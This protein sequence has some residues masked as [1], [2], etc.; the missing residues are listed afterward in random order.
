MPDAAR[1]R[2]AVVVTD[3][4][5]PGDPDRDTPALLAALRG[6]GAH[7]QAAVWHDG[8]VEWAGFDLAVLRTPW[9]WATRRAEF[10]GWLDRV[11][12]LTRVLNPPPLVRWN[13]DKRYLAELAQA[14]IAVV[15]TTYHRD[16]DHLPDALAA[17]TANAACDLTAHVV[18]KPAHGAGAVGTGLFRA[19]DPAA[20]TLAREVLRGGDTVLLQPEIA[21]L[22]AGEE[23]A[24]YLIDGE[25][26]HAIAKGALLARGGGLIGGTYTENP[27][28][29]PIEDDERELARRVLDAAL[30]CAGQTERALY[31]RIDLVRSA[32]HGLV[33][34][35]A[36]LFEPFFNLHLVPEV[37]ERFA[38]AV[39]AR[40]A[41]G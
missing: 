24:V 17:H 36:E 27:R 9:D 33:V 11:E 18:V 3:Q 16:A 31:A 38:G 39:L 7:A 28:L 15:P 13:L 6:R 32:E 4:Y 2:I 12:P 20:L 14:G 25:V 37:A 34:L 19:D 35:E 5:G 22:S 30:A 23:K 41:S 10:L 29:V 8:R 1:A 26:T 21:E 40:L